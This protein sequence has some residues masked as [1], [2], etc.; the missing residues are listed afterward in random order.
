M[1]PIRRENNYPPRRRQGALK[2]ITWPAFMLSAAAEGVK[3]AVPEWIRGLVDEAE[4]FIEGNFDAAMLAVRKVLEPRGLWVRATRKRLPYLKLTEEQA[5][6]VTR[7]E[8][9]VNGIIIQHISLLLDTMR[10]L[11]LPVTPHVLLGRLEKL[12]KPFRLLDL[13]RE[14]RDKIYEQ[15]LPQGRSIW[16]LDTGLNLRRPRVMRTL[17]ASCSQLRAECAAFYYGRNQIELMDQYC[18][19][20]QLYDVQRWA[21]AVGMANLRHLRHLTVWFA[22]YKGSYYKFDITYSADTGLHVGL[23]DCCDCD[24]EDE[25]DTAMEYCALIERRKAKEGWEST[26]II[27]YLL[28]DPDALRIAICGPPDY[29]QDL[30]AE[31]DEHDAYQVA[32]GPPPEAHTVCPW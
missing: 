14:L 29:V 28:S 6:K 15:L 11:E 3:D 30:E 17:S 16:E 24:Q 19:G 25:T 13:P 10:Y 27:E 18:Y 12:C 26:G 2:K 23:V 31:S 9:W 32:Y 1:R 22:Y 5:Y 7:Q 8:Y 20:G 4:Q 21:D